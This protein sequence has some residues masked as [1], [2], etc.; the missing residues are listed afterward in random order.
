MGGIVLKH[1]WTAR[2]L[3][4]IRQSMRLIWLC[5]LMLPFVLGSS[6]LQV[7]VLVLFHCSVSACPS[8]V[9]TGLQATGSTQPACVSQI[10]LL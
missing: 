4:C 6:A 8:A 7:L 2:Q 3:A 9:Y 5:S 10:I 1:Q